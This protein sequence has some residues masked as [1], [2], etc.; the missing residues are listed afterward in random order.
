MLAIHYLIEIKSDPENLELFNQ[1]QPKLRAD[2]NGRLTLMSTIKGCKSQQLPPELF[3]EVLTFAYNSP[4]L[5]KCPVSTK[6]ITQY[7]NNIYRSISYK[8]SPGV[9]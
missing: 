5:D 3:S 9:I 4:N 1:L 2:K 7:I 8:K 6:N